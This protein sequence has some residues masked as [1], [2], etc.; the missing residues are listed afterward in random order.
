MEQ[1]T[2]IVSNF[3]HL[4]KI[5]RMRLGLSREKVAEEL[6]LNKQSIGHIERTADNHNI[7]RYLKL[8]KKKGVDIN[9]LF[10]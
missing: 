7:V 8:L 9:K 3:G 10:E 2:N 5:E 1:N 4:I 6:N